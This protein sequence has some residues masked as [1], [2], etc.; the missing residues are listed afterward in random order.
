MDAYCCNRNTGKPNTFTGVDVA[1]LTGGVY[2]A[3]TL[4]QKNNFACLAYQAAAGAKPDVALGL[5]N[6]LL[7]AVGRVTNGLSC[8]QLSKIDNSQL[9]QFP[10]YTRSPAAQ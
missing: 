3:Q 2:N 1:N 6:T 4:G 7:G 9:R 8:P 5:T 10:G